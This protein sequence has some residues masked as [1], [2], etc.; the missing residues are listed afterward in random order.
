MDIERIS[1]VLPVDDLAAAVAGWAALLGVEPIFVDA[2]R[3]AQFDVAG[4][5]I[6][7]AGTDRVGDGVALMA[8]VADLAAAR[9]EALRLGYAAG[10]PE[11]GP[12]ELRCTLEGPG[13]TPVVLYSPAPR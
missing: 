2:G 8:K 9:A 5:R 13:G 3:W 4:A 7:L 1:L 10:E 12:H 6:A 11:A